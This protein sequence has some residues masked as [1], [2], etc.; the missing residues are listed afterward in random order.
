MGHMMHEMFHVTDELSLSA[1]LVDHNNPTK[2]VQ[3]TGF[4]KQYHMLPEL[5][6][7]VL[8]VVIGLCKIYYDPVVFRNHCRLVQLPVGTVCTQHPNIRAWPET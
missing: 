8:H 5:S 3:S 2:S 4:I 1:V 6:S 7:M